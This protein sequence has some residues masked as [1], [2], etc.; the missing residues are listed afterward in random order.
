[1]TH[2]CPQ[3][4]SAIDSESPEGLCPSCLLTTAKP[5]SAPADQETSANPAAGQTITR[6]SF[7]EG[8]GTIIGN[9]KLLQLIGEGGFG[10]VFMAE[11]LRPVHRRVAL[12]VI[13]LGMDT[14]QVIAR[15]EAERQALAMMDH[16]NIAKILDAGE[17]AGGRPYFVMELVRGIPI[18]EYCDTN[19][20]TTADRLHLFIAVCNAVQH[21]HQ[22]G[23]IHRD[24]KPTNVLVTLHDGTP[25]PK[26]IDF[27]IAKATQARLTEMT[28]FTEFRQLIGTPAYMSPE[29]AEISGLDV[30]TRSDIYSL[31]VLLYELLTGTTPFDPKEMRSAAYAEIQRIIR[32]VDPPKPSTRLSTLGEPLATVAANRSVEPR[33]LGQLVRGDLDWVV[34]KAMEKDRT[35]RYQSAGD[36]A[37]DIGRHLSDQPV[38]AGP[39]SASYRLRKFVRRN[40][41]VVFTSIAAFV[42]I[43][44][45]GATYIHG[46][47]AA[48]LK[49][50]LALD[51]ASA[52]R[53]EAQT[54]KRLA[55]RQRDEAQKQERI[56][57]SANGFLSTMLSSAD[58]E[59]LL[60][61]KVT[62]VQAIEAA[63]KQLDSGSGQIDPLTEAS[64]RDTIGKTLYGLGRYNEAEP[65][66]R[67]ALAL[68]RQALP[69]VCEEMFTSLT[70]LGMLL[71]DE[72][73]LEEAEDSMRE[74]LSIARQG[75]PAKD[76]EIDTALNN[77]SVVLT[78]E[79]DRIKWDE[80]EKLLRE[81]LQL[82]QA[83]IPIDRTAISSSLNNLAG[84]YVAEERYS[85]AQPLY[86]E[87]LRI[88]RA[89]LPAGHPDIAI[90]LI[91][92]AR[93][94]G[95][96]E[97]EK[98]YR[99]ALEIDRKAL[100]AGHPVIASL[101]YN[102]AIL[103]QNQGRLAEAEK[104]YR[105]AL[106]IQQT[107]LPPTHPQRAMTMTNL[108]NLLE[109]DH[110]PAEAEPLYLGALE[111]F[112][113]KD[114]V[115]LAHC[116]EG[117][118]VLLM[119]HQRLAEAEPRLRQALEVHRRVLPAGHP[120]LANDL[121]N[122]A[123]VLAD[124]KEAPEAEKL[125]TEATEILRKAGPDRRSELTR[126]LTQFAILLASEK[127][128][129]RAIEMFR[130]V[131][132]IDR[133]I[134][135]AGS[136]DLGRDLNN[137][138]FELAAQNKDQEAEML[139][140]EALD[141]RRKFLPERYEDVT[142]TINNLA[143]LL[144]HQKNDAEAE[145]LYREQLKIVTQVP[146]PITLEIA[147]AQND[148]GAVLSHGE[149]YV[150]AEPLIRAA[151]D[152]RQKELGPLDDDTKTTVTGLAWLL[153][154]TGRSKEASELR[155][156][157]GIT[158][159]ATRPAGSAS[160]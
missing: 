17:T 117:L 4:G 47:R 34:M 35:R 103:L 25:V 90:D 82:R 62:V 60:G 23:I 56:A 14:R 80:A 18:T 50:Q 42:L 140:R 131:L 10:S 79:N 136:A 75:L 19:K 31:G 152:V 26:L 51:E 68:R 119:N 11:Q 160:P 125:Y 67:R 58:P 111:I 57:K 59:K 84:L 81:A 149:K 22:K 88:D 106:Q 6:E 144:L 112:G 72:H 33:T 157:H 29:Q 104:V 138:A 129:D 48:Q 44:I 9:Y 115:D 154:H 118:G 36:L 70:N 135:P 141:A 93:V 133:E 7:K 37:R 63:E 12:K 20:L 123:S 43:L 110:R 52:Q 24:I 65:N 89:A 32:E 116:L 159:A 114:D 127:K 16:P 147:R 27:G 101:L 137:L 74:A 69:H 130:E 55:D 83:R 91:D 132:A 96:E 54:Q 100:P 98:D 148:L 155:A 146:H 5:S 30:D 122:L 120:D 66:L 8:V 39:P 102:L 143:R 128:M 3:C 113:T 145:S 126:C 142:Q 87:A 97:S 45:A 49:T 99:E 38:E 64:L 28:M 121:C 95:P 94:V 53:A 76:P 108:A 151:L 71:G 13:K 78:Q 15:F 107:A 158:D 40:R 153:D 85:D 139:Y 2:L 86:Q 1:M 92:L 21:A 77:L 41:T 46:I 73:K 150:E 156:A 61:D 134:L 105:E 124:R 109:Q